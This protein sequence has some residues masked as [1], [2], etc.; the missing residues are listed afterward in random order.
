MHH[1]ESTEP[2]HVLVKNTLDAIPGLRVLK[3]HH[4]P[5]REVEN[6]KTQEKERIDAIAIIIVN[7]LTGVVEALHSELGLDRIAEHHLDG[8][9][10][11]D[12]GIS[13]KCCNQI[14]YVRDVHTQELRHLGP[15]QKRGSGEYEQVFVALNGDP[16]SKD[17]FTGAIIP[18]P[19]KIKQSRLNL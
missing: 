17:R 6:V 8:Y 3:Y 7:S 10:A 19:N 1:S 15:Y 16:K 4:Y 13:G 5:G 14:C 11:D 12:R 2:L 18:P 9:L